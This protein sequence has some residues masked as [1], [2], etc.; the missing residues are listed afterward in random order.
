MGITPATAALPG[1]A[2]IGDSAMLPAPM[3]V[4]IQRRF[5]GF[6]GVA[7]GGWVGGFLA[8]DLAAAEVKLRRPVPVER[9]LQIEARDGGVREL[10]DGGEVLARMRPA[11]LALPIPR[12]VSPGEAAAAAAR[13]LQRSGPPYR[14]P[15]CFTCGDGR[16]EGDGLRLF[17]GPVSGREVVAAPWTP[18]PGLADGAGHVRPEFVW[19][20]LDCPTIMAAVFASPAD[21]PERV[22]TRQLAVSRTGA[23]RAGDAH[24]VMAWC[25]SREGRVIVTF[26]AI[27][28][29]TG[30]V[31][32]AAEHRLAVASWGVPLGRE[33]RD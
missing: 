12:P 9:T 8:G 20:A 21:A 29:A 1:L 19:S 2:R 23:I 30:Q 24:A 13:S 32:A 5:R 25:G 14:F 3:D 22:V 31:L 10:L 16:A 28:S 27:L 15:G 18:H 26:G 7:L 6:E 11:V 4:L 33:R 17:A